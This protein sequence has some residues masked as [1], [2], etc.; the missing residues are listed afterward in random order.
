METWDI[1]SAVGSTRTLWIRGGAIHILSSSFM[2]AW[3]A[4]G[5]IHA[6]DAS[7]WV[8][9]LACAYSLRILHVPAGARMVRQN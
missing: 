6:L 9:C 3:R 2:D 4:F 8:L 1:A 5:I 7:D